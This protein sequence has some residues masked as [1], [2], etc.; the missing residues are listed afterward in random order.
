LSTLELE[1]L[2]GILKQNIQLLTDIDSAR[3]SDIICRHYLPDLKLFIEDLEQYPVHQL[4]LIHAVLQLYSYSETL[5]SLKVK[6]LEL[7]AVTG[8]HD[9]ILD[10]LMRE[11][12]A[13][14]ESL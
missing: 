14:D 10:E 5:L 2:K 6:Y 12:Y 11:N 13:L 4:K 3:A 8:Q 1:F 7:L 9:T